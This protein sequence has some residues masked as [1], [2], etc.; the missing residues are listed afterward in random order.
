MRGA[1]HVGVGARVG[2]DEVLAAGLADDARVVPVARQVLADLAPQPLE[3][4]GGAGE[5]QPR[6]LRVAQRHVGH[7]AAV[8]GDQVDDAGRHPGLLEQLH[9][10]LRGELLRVRGLPHDGVAHQRRRGRQ[11]AGD[12][13]EVE[14]GH[15]V[16]TKPAIRGEA[17]WRAFDYD[18]VLLLSCEHV[19]FSGRRRSS[20]PMERGRACGSR[21]MDCLV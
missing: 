19:R 1:Q 17:R 21:E 20:A 13:G 15:G 6:E 8:A 4:R 14:R 3:D 9:G 11:V 7:L 2:Q 10:Q 12:R 16:G 5:V 18:Y